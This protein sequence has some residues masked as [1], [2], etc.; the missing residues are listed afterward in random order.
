MNISTFRLDKPAYETL[1]AFMLDNPELR[2]NEA[3]VH[4]VDPLEY[5]EIFFLAELSEEE[6]HEDIL[7]AALHNR[8]VIT[9]R[10][11]EAWIEEELLEHSME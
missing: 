6:E 9:K 8:G 7:H 1:V 11:V 4:G 3:H 2:T 10:L 5:P